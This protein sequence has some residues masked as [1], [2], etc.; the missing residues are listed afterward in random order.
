MN[1]IFNDEIEILGS[2]L[3]TLITSKYGKKNP[4]TVT[5]ISDNLDIEY[6]LLATFNVLRKFRPLIKLNFIKHNSEHANDIGKCVI[7]SIDANVYENLDEYNSVYNEGNHNI[8]IYFKDTCNSKYELEHEQYKALSEMEQWVKF[9]S[10]KSKSKFI[11]ASNAP[12]IKQDYKNIDIDNL[13]EKEYECIISKYPKGS[14]EYFQYTLEKNCKVIQDNF[15]YTKIRLDNIFGPFINNLNLLGLD[16]LLKNLLESKMI[17]ANVDNCITS[18][19]VRD[20]IIAIFYCYLCGKNNEAYNITNYRTLYSEVAHLIY[21]NFMEE[22]ILLNIRCQYNKK[23]SLIGFTNL[24]LK[25]LKWKPSI[26]FTEAIYRTCCVKLNYEY[27]MKHSLKIYDGKLSRIKYLELEMLREVD[28][29]CKENN[30]KY[31]LVGGSLLGAVRHN[32]FIPWDDDLDIGMLREDY[33]RFRSICPQNLSDKYFYQSF[34]YDSNCHYIFDKIRLKNTYFSTK[35]SNRFNI[36]NGIFLDILVYDRTSNHKKIQKLHIKIIR[37]WNRIINLRWINKARKNIHYRKSKFA[38][39]IIRKIPF[40]YFHKLLEATLKLY[41]NHTK[42]S[43]LIDGVGQ[44]I[45][46]GAFNSSWFDELIYV[47]FEDFTVPI[48][49]QYDSYLKHWYGEKY[50]NYPLLSKRNSGHSL[51]RIDLGEYIMDE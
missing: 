11:L 9:A 46:K 27:D 37:V 18:I 43:Y 40:S 38:L 7:E 51:A 3:R 6:Y 41:K 5:I 16:D 49:K 30:I 2:K 14:I 21:K 33:E 22:N 32:G 50:M 39:P 10:D 42:S 48:P 34:L 12:H 17:Y 13:S 4:I 19:Y 15:K 44:N 25:S 26:S 23:N 1:D 20:A 47:P 35:F 36:E 29:I 8:F 24:T 28:K 45:Y 31:F